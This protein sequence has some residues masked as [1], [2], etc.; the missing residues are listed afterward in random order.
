LSPR[1][2]AAGSADASR[3]AG[4]MRRSAAERRRAVPPALHE[5]LAAAPID[6]LHDPNALSNARATIGGSS[7]RFQRPLFRICDCREVWRQGHS[8][9][10][11]VWLS[12]QPGRDVKAEGTRLS[13]LPIEVEAHTSGRVPCGEADGR[14]QHRACAQPTPRGIGGGRALLLLATGL[15]LHPHAAHE[16]AILGPEQP[17]VAA[18]EDLS[19]AATY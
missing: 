2:W 7:R 16:L 3:R 19:K 15:Q 18:G 14:Q 11:A 10:G 9:A 1:V 12:G 4:G 13:G 5:A 8:H 6:R 17:R